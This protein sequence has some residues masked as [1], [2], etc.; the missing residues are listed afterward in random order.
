M[1]ATIQALD[2][3]ESKVKSLEAQRDSLEFRLKEA[4]E[5]IIIANEVILQGARQRDL[6]LKV[7][8]AAKARFEEWNNATYRGTKEALEA[9]DAAYPE[10]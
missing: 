10:A 7:R 6:L 5:K 2:R 8:D 1:T 9:Y 3:A 4:I